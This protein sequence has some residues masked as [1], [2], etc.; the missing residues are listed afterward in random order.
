MAG[1]GGDVSDASES[2]ADLS[3]QLIRACKDGA[4]GKL[5]YLVEVKHVD[6]HSRRD[7]EY[8]ATQLHF[9]L[10]YGHLDIVRYL[11]GEQQCDVEC[12]DKNGNTPLHYAAHGGRLD[13]MQCLISGSGCDPMCIEVGMVELF[14]MMHVR[15]VNLI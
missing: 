11:V 5:K 1:E 4:L 6:P 15:Q 9:A 7:G 13:T 14:F 8:G 2:S 3:G 12:R 10:L